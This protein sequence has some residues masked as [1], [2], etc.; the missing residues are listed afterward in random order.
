LKKQ[1]RESLLKYDTK[2]SLSEGKYL[3][4]YIYEV[5]RGGPLKSSKKTS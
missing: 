3:N 1:F 5:A 4:K 2:S